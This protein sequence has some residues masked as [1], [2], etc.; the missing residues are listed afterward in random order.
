MWPTSHP[1]LIYQLFGN[2]SDVGLTPTQFTEYSTV[3][4]YVQHRVQLPMGVITGSTYDTLPSDIYIYIQ[5]YKRIVYIQWP[6]NLP[7][8]TTNF[9]PTNI[10]ICYS[11][12]ISPLRFQLYHH[13]CF[14]FDHDSC[15]TYIAIWSC[16]IWKWIII[17]LNILTCY[18]AWRP[19]T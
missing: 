13:F 12:T 18:D 10:P 6:N 9:H 11:N 14:Q 3:I 4:K 1:Q 2:T 15:K 17:W 7:R 16:C 19:R 5:R 8:S